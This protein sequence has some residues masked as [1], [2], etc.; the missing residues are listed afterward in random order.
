M[1]IKIFKREKLKVHIRD[2]TSPFNKYV[3][4]FAPALLQRNT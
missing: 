4:F 2:R 1:T 3:S